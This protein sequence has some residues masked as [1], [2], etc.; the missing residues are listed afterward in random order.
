M[1]LPNT[2]DVGKIIKKLNTEG[3]RSRTQKIAIA[4]NIARKAGAN[5]PLPP[6]E[7][8]RQIFKNK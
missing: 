6:D 7:T 8:M 4:L 1:P 3:G 5:I 2:I